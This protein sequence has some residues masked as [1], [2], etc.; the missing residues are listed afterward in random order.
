M[1]PFSVV[2]D[3]FT[4]CSKSL[5]LYPDLTTWGSCCSSGARKERPAVHESP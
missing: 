5:A 1:P 2:P 3:A 4:F